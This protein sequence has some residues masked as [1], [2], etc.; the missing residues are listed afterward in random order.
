M[1]Q[2][3]DT[4]EW[5]SP[6][7][8]TEETIIE[9]SSRTRVEYRLYLLAVWR[10]AVGDRPEYSWFCLCYLVQAC[11]GGDIC[12]GLPGVRKVEQV[13]G[14]LSR[15]ENCEYNNVG[16][17]KGNVLWRAKEIKT[18]FKIGLQ[19]SASKVSEGRYKRRY[20]EGGLIGNFTFYH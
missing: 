8:L 3:N 11:S 6:H 7:S 14:G 16:M 10:S 2:L 15:R 19:G 13:R 9:E 4:A 5:L 18:T 1:N 12:P 20:S 17:W